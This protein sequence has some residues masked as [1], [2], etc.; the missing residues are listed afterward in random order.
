MYD[1]NTYDFDGDGIPDA[2]DQ[3]PDAP[4]SQ[5]E[6]GC[7]GDNS[8]TV[9]DDQRDKTQGCPADGGSQPCGTGM[10]GLV[11]NLSS[12]NFVLEDKD[13]AYTDINRTIEINRSYNAYST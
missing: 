4:P 3:N 10:P 11:V 6:K 7:M 5:L 2:Q 1:P 9:Y 13:I 12:L 8:N